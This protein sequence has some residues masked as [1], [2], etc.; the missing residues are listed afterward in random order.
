MWALSRHLLRA[1]SDI[2]IDNQS[3]DLIKEDHQVW[4]MR[5]QRR[6]VEWAQPLMWTCLF[7]SKQFCQNDTR[8]FGKMNYTQL[9]HCYKWTNYTGKTGALP[10]ADTFSPPPPSPTTSWSLV[11]CWSLHHAS[12]QLCSARCLFSNQRVMRM[13][14]FSHSLLLEAAPGNEFPDSGCRAEQSRFIIVTVLV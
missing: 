3:Q 12:V 10:G 14:F 4:E 6:V 11:E 2:S 13:T 1:E 8:K 9:C 5:S 7:T